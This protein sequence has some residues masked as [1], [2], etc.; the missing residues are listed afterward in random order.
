MKPAFRIATALHASL[1]RSA[2]AIPG[3]ATSS[4]MVVM[5]RRNK[6][7]HSHFDFAAQF[8]SCYRTPGESEIA[9]ITR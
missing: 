8:W 4:P 6:P 9:L 7:H 1:L 5:P 3:C 2:R